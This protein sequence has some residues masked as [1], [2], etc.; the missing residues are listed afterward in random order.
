[1]NKRPLSTICAPLSVGFRLLSRAYRSSRLKRKL[2]ST[3]LCARHLSLTVLAS[4]MLW[5]TACA[6]V[7]TAPTDP[8]VPCPH[9]IVS[10]ATVGG[11]TRGLLDYADALDYCN[12]LRGFAPEAQTQK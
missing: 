2:T 1:M 4:L 3:R 9:P 10:T 6:S 12:A 11:L 5:L 7:S 8:D